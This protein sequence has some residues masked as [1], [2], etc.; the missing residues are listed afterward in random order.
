MN[1][2]TWV[3]TSLPTK[4]TGMGLRTATDTALPAYLASMHAAF[5]LLKEILPDAKVDRDDIEGLAEWRATS[6]IEPTLLEDKTAQAS[7]DPTLISKSFD[8]AMEHADVVSKARLLASSTA[9]SGAWLEALPVSTLGNLLDDTTFKIAF[10]L[11]V[12]GRISQEH[13]C[14][15]G[16]AADGFGHHGL[17]CERSKGRFRRHASLNETIKR[18]LATANVP[19]VLEPTGLSR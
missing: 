8:S 19:S 16:K 5:D 12:G 9:E 11:R 4:M 1:D 13:R 10:A 14:I 7:W 17:V 2:R 3:Q 18:A 15:C 6:G